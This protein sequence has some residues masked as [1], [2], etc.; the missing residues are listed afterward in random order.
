MCVEVKEG[1]FA[2]KVIG[3]S[4]GGFELGFIMHRPKARGWK[5]TLVINDSVVISWL[6]RNK[7]KSLVHLRGLGEAKI[8]AE[9]IYNGWLN[10]IAEVEGDG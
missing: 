6:K 8:R 9:E 2:V 10:N 3:L 1:Y 7:R 4:S 5:Y